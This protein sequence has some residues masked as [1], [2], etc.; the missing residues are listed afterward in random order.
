MAGSM[1]GILTLKTGYWQLS[2]PMFGRTFGPII[3]I[4]NSGGA[5]FLDGI[6]D[7]IVSS[8]LRVHARVTAGRTR[9][10]R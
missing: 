10:R 4:S 1:A 6:S 9:L 3:G 8:V 2:G 7:G 5:T